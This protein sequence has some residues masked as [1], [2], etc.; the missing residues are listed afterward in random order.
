MPSRFWFFG[1]AVLGS[2][3]TASSSLAHSGDW[4]TMEVSLS[5]EDQCR[6][7]SSVTLTNPGPPPGVHCRL[8][9]PYRLSLAPR[10]T[11]PDQQGSMQRVALNQGVW[12]I[13]F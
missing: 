4:V 11:L 2:F 12:E 8:G 1:I 13:E 9:S 7:V 10:S 3:I 5:I 6:I